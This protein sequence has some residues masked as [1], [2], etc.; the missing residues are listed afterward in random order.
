[1]TI[2]IH[3]T[4][5]NAE[6]RNYPYLEALKSFCAV[7]DEVIVV[8]GG[9]TD[10]SVEKMTALDPKI[11][12]ITVP[13]PEEYDQSEFPRHL[14]AGLNACTGDWAIKCDIDYVFH[15]K[16]ITDLQVRLRGFLH[17]TAVAT[18]EKFNVV[19]RFRGFRKAR[20]PFCINK[21]Y[22]GES[23]KYGR[24]RNVPNDDWSYPIMVK[25]WDGDIPSGDPIPAFMVRATG[26]D[27]WNYDYFFRTEEETRK[28][29]AR[30]AP[31]LNPHDITG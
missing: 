16:E 10:G 21:S 7:A 13:W 15:E 27:V 25:E 11:K 30:N 28:L 17:D 31:H 24:Q 14:N 22:A 1:M 3:T 20:I 29:F 5:T 26:I 12:V 23:I 19:N 6:E 4:T 18:L 9:S 2:S 8:D